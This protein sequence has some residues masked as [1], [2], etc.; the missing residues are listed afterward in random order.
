MARVDP[1]G[2]RPNNFELTI[3]AHYMRSQTRML[4][5][6]ETQM[7]ARGQDARGNSEDPIN[8][9]AEF[10]E[11]NVSV[12]KLHGFALPLKCVGPDA[13]YLMKV[14]KD[15]CAKHNQMGRPELIA[16][17]RHPDPLKC[18][19]DATATVFILRFAKQ[20]FLG[21]GTK[22]GLPNFFDYNVDW[23]AEHCMLTTKT[24][25]GR[26]KYKGNKT[27]GPGHLE[28]FQDMKDA[29][30]LWGALGDC[31]T[32]LRSF[33]AMNAIMFNAEY[34]ETERAGR[35]NSRFGATPGTSHVM[36]KHYLR[37]PSIQVAMAGVDLDATQRN[38]YCIPHQRA[39]ES[40]TPDVAA[41]ADADAAAAVAA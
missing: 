33:G 32:K 14:L 8:E 10:D 5:L 20:G 19:L 30:G 31:A 25:K 41:A 29:A 11:S 40:S 26:L 6:M 34:L 4:A 35:W 37:M 28:L 7:M 38:N 18:C 17:T 24:G 27:I 1:R 15:N 36:N 9:E 22:D 13:M 2:K 12:A 23:Q 21:D 3:E 16:A 39:G